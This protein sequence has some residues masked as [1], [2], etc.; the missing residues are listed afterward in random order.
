MA[1]AGVIQFLREHVVRVEL[2]TT[3]DTQLLKRFIAD[4]DEAALATLVRRHGAMV[5]GVCKRVLYQDQD[6]ED[7]FQATFVVLIR[8]AASIRPPSML[9]N[10]LYGVAH[11]I[12]VKA[13]AMNAKRLS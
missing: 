9:G 1:V 8:K 12:S 10:W 6:A 13:R 11:Q 3:T 4:R 7:A 2:E 5:W